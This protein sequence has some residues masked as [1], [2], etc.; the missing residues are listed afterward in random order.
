MEVELVVAAVVL[1]GGE[2][3]VLPSLRLFPSVALYLGLTGKTN[4]EK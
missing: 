4:T 2:F 1:Y 3:V